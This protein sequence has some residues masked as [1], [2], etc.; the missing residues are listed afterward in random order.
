MVV[1]T[2]V[3]CDAVDYAYAVRVLR[4]PYDDVAERDARSCFKIFPAR[5]VAPLWTGVLCQRPVITSCDT[6]VRHLFADGWTR[7]TVALKH[8]S[9]SDFRK[10]REILLTVQSDSRSLRARA[11]NSR[12]GNQH[13][14][15]IGG[16][17]YVKNSVLTAS[18]V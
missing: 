6:A 9:E 13:S 8:Q 15:E 4:Y 10:P 17:P 3:R 1:G 18:S 2:R 5:P 14:L 16:V 7:P 11:H 12:D